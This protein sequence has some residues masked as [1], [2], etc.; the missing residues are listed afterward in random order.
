MFHIKKGSTD[1]KVVVKTKEELNAAVKRKEPCIEV[2]GSLVTKI[3]W[4]KKLSAAKIAAL[5]ALLASAVIPSPIAPI[6][7]CAV[8]S[9]SAATAVSAITGTEIAA[10]ILAGGLSA[11]MILAVLK[12]YNIE[13]DDENRS[14]RLSRK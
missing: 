7:M 10:I 6:S 9:G 4:M 2:Q 3:K 11:T 13:V 12:D 1:K 14:M 8:A 5:V